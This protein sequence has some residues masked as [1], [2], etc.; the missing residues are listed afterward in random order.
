MSKIEFNKFLHEKRVF[1][2]LIAHCLCDEKHMIVKHMLLFCSKKKEEKEE[3][4]I[5]TK[6]KD[7]EHKIIL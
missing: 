3:K 7:Y 2:V 1:D 5:V 4:E 6:S